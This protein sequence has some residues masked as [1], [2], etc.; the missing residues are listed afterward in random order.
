MSR[1]CRA[2]RVQ[3]SPLWQCLDESLEAF[4]ADFCN[5]HSKHLG[6]LDTSRESALRDSLRCGDLTSG[7]LRVQCPDC[8]YHYLLPFICKR[9][10]CCPSCYQRRAHDTETF[11]L[12]TP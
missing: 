5:K 9:P 3:S 10:A 11:T 12:T 7:F 6:A 2:R 4:T 8:D 1:Q